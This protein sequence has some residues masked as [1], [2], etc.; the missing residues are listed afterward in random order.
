MGRGSVTA[1]TSHSAVGLPTSALELVVERIRL[2]ARRRASWLRALWFE[3]GLPLH[4]FG[5]DGRV[6]LALT[7]RDDPEAERRWLAVAP[8]VHALG[9]RLTAVEDR[10]AADDHSRLWT[11]RRRFELTEPEDHVLQTVV[12]IGLEP[13]LGGAFAQ[14]QGDPR[15]TYPTESIV[16]RLFLHGRRPLVASDSPLRTWGLVGTAEMGPGEPAALSCDPDLLH[17]VQGGRGLDRALVGAARFQ[18][19]LPPLPAW[20]VD[21][22]AD[23]VLSLLARGRPVRVVVA[24]LP[25]SGRMT[26][27][28]VVSERLGRRLLR[29]EADT[30]G[31][32]LWPDLYLRS[33]RQAIL[34]GHAVG[35]AGDLPGVEPWPRS[36]PVTPLQFVT[37]Q[38]GDAPV[39]VDGV[40]DLA[41][42]LPG[43]SLRERE[44]LW[45]HLLP[46]SA[47]WD[48]HELGRLARRRTTTV[49]EIAAL[50]HREIRSARDAATQL[51]RGIRD[52]FRPLAQPLECPFR[53][54]D[55]VVGSTLRSALEDL[56]FEARERVAFWE[57][58][59]ARRLFPQGRGLLSL[60][61]GPPGTG[62]TMAAQIIAAELDQALYRIDISAVVSKY[63][64][65]TSRHLDR[66]LSRASRMDVVLLFD[67][68]DALFGRRTRVEDS[69]D[70]YANTDTSYLLQAIES[71]PGVAVLTTNRKGNVDPAFIRRLR[72]V[73]DFP[74]PDADQRNRIWRR[75]LGELAG[76]EALAALS[77]DLKRLARDVEATGA[78]IKGAVL[79]G[80]FAALRD[81][82]SL[83]L[84]H[85]VHGLHRELAKE[86]RAF[87][88]R[89]RERF[90][91]E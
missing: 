71:Y 28:A 36:Q 22:V 32:D 24:G 62:K 73:L 21:E 66:V 79:S 60:F 63:V 15:R 77:G 86:G 61:S 72:Y 70:R 54:D 34:D 41:L 5:E 59:E 43:L 13:A 52:R 18:E 50:A 37:A 56:A 68:C 74:R 9:R 39:E 42:E 75:I 6:D 30:V 47:Q 27:A 51:S 76:R 14:I 26:F 3:D 4:E 29:V 81:G 53:W 40:A 85:L 65:E 10:L 58:A 33:Q 87:S 48:E 49:G 80:V 83:D 78:Q 25:G 88:E 44:R 91:G 8:E 55:L 1:T 2:R 38:P 19:V 16:A 12:A 57:R 31:P 69:H 11:L 45:Q 84:S 23:R 35:W 17:W 20:P 90:L 46:A 7:G 82:N 89:E 64:G 67:E